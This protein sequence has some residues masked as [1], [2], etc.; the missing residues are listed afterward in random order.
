MD[1]SLSLERYKVR[2]F[3]KRWGHTYTFRSYKLNQFNEPTTE[4]EKAL[5]VQGV[6]HESS[7]YISQT[8]ED[9]GTVV[10]KLNTW[11]M[12]LSESA[13]GLESEMKVDI[14]GTT[15]RVTGV[16]DLDKLGL[17]CDVSLEEVLK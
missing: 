15:F 8:V 6:Y 3:I 10:S 16:R 12:C 1:H 17:A 13:V 2:Q 11:L 4:V 5:E 9:S 7:G 14:A